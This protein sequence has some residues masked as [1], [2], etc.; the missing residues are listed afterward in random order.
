MKIKNL[1]KL[2]LSLIV[3]GIIFYIGYLNLPKSENVSEKIIPEVQE[4]DDSNVENKSIVLPFTYAMDF[5]ED[6]AA[7]E[8][9]GK[10]GFIN[11]KGEWQ[12]KP[13]FEDAR[14][15]SEGVASVKINRKWG[16][17][18]KTGKIMSE[19]KFD[20]PEDL[21]G[22]NQKFKN[23]FDIIIKSPKG[24]ERICAIINKHGEIISDWLPYGWPYYALLNSILSGSNINSIKKNGKYGFIEF[25][26]DKYN[27]IIPPKYEDAISGFSEG[28]AA[29]KE[30]GKWGYIDITGKM[31]IT[32]QF[33]SAFNFKGNYARVMLGD[34][35]GAINKQGET[36]FTIDA[37]FLVDFSEGLAAF[38]NENQE[39]GFVN[40]Q[41]EIVI[42]AK[43]S[44]GDTGD[45]LPDKMFSEG[46]CDVMSS[47]NNKIGYIDKQGRW[48][49]QPQ[50]DWASSFKD[51]VALVQ[52]DNKW[53]FINK[54]G[55]LITK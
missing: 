14:N 40:K 52:L 20:Y 24:E 55:E 9:N 29:V 27:E 42:P 13:T 16:L 53:G 5:S 39:F 54:K 51:N 8:F 32:P 3:T 33:D 15:F 19:P 21:P 48:I 37:S 2:V 28:L 44:P 17:I 30:N 36:L 18:D 47:E 43:Y 26:D 4:P 34:K 6:L 23:G 46:L 1:K 7:V 22:A 35:W 10:Y 41:G 31:V 38:F 45:F 49:I 50:F 25:K 12:I 11:K